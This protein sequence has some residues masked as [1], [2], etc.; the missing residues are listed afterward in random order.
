MAQTNARKRRAGSTGMK[1]LIAAASVGATLVGWAV[2]PGNDPQ[3]ASGAGPAVQNDQGNQL[4]AFTVPSTTNDN[5]QNGSQSGSGN[6]LPSV[7]P[8]DQN[9][10]PQVQVPDPN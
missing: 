2:L 6:Q 10:Q 5:G 4:P 1:A 8:P 3:N 7:Q 9:Q